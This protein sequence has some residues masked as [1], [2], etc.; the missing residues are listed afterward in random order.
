MGRVGCPTAPAMSMQY[1][2]IELTAL[3]WVNYFN[4]FEKILVSLFTPYIN[5]KFM[6]NKVI[7][8]SEK[9]PLGNKGKN[10]DNKYIK[11]PI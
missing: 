2:T 7:L 4:F 11:A 8:K 10:V 5:D 3:Y 1:S 9:E 6:K